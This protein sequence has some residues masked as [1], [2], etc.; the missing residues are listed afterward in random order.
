MSKEIAISKKDKALAVKSMTTF[1]LKA[2]LRKSTA[3]DVGLAVKKFPRI[4]NRDGTPVIDKKTGKQKY[5]NDVGFQKKINVAIKKHIGY[6]CDEI[7]KSENYLLS[8]WVLATRTKVTM[9]CNM[10]C[11]GKEFIYVDDYENFKEK[12]DCDM[13]HYYNTF[14]SDLEQMEKI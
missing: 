8:D 13:Q 6:Y 4:I 9:S 10:F 7:D 11:K 12:I 1:E 2:E 14:K 5:A 3:I